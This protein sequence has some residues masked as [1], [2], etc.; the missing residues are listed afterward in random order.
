MELIITKNNVNEAFERLVVG[1]IK[2]ENYNK[3]CFG[4]SDLKRAWMMNKVLDT[5]IS[6]TVETGYCQH[7]LLGPTLSKYGYTLEVPK[8][9]ALKQEADDSFCIDMRGYDRAM[10]FSYHVFES[11][12]ESIN[13]GLM[14]Y[15]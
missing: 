15:R 11:T 14:A 4:T 6:K 3:D 7:T 1:L 12:V 2:A 13:E 9:E 10:E 8:N 5:F